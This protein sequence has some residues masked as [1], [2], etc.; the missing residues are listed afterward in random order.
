MPPGKVP[1]RRPGPLMITASDAKINVS[2]PNVGYTPVV[3]AFWVPG[4]AALT[5]VAGPRQPSA[6]GAPASAGSGCAA[7]RLPTR[8]SSTATTSETTAMPATHQNQVP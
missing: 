6:P 8:Y 2:A 7:D 3:P 5:G 4:R 1:Q